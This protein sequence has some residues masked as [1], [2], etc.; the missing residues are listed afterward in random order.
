MKTFLYERLNEKWTEEMIIVYDCTIL[1]KDELIPLFLE[2][3]AFASSKFKSLGSNIIE[4]KFQS[5]IDFQKVYEDAMAAQRRSF[6]YEEHTCG[7][8]TR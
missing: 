7:I 5:G 1:I 4:L 6:N 8:C 3:D 2:S